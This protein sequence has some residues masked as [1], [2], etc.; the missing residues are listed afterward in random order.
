ML[1]NKPEK[2]Q[3]SYH[4]TLKKTP[5]WCIQ[6]EE[7]IR[8]VQSKEELIRLWR[9]QLWPKNIEAMWIALEGPS[10][11]MQNFVR[12]KEKLEKWIGHED[13]SVL[14]TNLKGTTGLAS[15]GPVVGISSVVKG[16]MSQEDYLLEF[17]HRGPHEF[18]LSIP[19]PR[20]NPSWL[21]K[22]IKEAKKSGMNVDE[23]LYKQREQNEMVW[24]RL[25]QRFP[26]RI[27]KLKRIVKKNF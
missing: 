13:T 15:L 22:Q 14:L 27:K 16:E 8:N 3:S 24:R 26:Y 11:K 17:G 18:E 19:G 6:T 23:L 7:L 4:S 10:S 25:E 2:L 21:E 5:N 20:E 1:L 9:E 12:W